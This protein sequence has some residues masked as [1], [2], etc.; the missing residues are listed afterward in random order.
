M[1]ADERCLALIRAERPITG[2]GGATHNAK[3]TGPTPWSGEMHPEAERAKR[4]SDTTTGDPHPAD[5]HSCN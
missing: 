3:T 5:G 4:S 2:Y 1:S